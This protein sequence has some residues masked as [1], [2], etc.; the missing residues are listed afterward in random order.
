MKLN[1]GITENKLE[2]AR[3]KITGS[4]KR[5]ISDVENASC[6]MIDDEVLITAGNL[7]MVFD[8]N[9][10]FKQVFIKQID[11]HDSTKLSKEDL[12]DDFE[13]YLNVGMTRE[14]NLFGYRILIN[15]YFKVML[16]CKEDIVISA[17][18][19]KDD[20]RGIFEE[21]NMLGVKTR[22]G[23]YLIDIDNLDSFELV[24]F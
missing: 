16:L 19:T 22:H 14:E 6:S 10:N 1:F 12:L 7:V 23:R 21:N 2:V 5:M 4:Y 3:C 15:N 20:I 9:M 18:A 8:K 24:V 13:R 11:S 17:Y